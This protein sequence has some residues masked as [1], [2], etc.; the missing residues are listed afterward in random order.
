MSQQEKQK[1]WIIKKAIDLLSKDSN[2][3]RY[4]ELANKIK[5]ENK[6]YIE[7]HQHTINTKSSGFSN[8]FI[9]SSNT[10]LSN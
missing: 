7:I 10:L 4:T 9:S 8:F 1:D 3:L 6:D 5:D 2:G